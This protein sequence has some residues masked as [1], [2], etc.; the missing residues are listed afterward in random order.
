MSILERMPMVTICLWI[1]SPLRQENIAN[2]T[3]QSISVITIIFSILNA[4]NLTRFI[5]HIRLSPS[6]TG[7]HFALRCSVGSHPRQIESIVINVET[8]G[9][10][11]HLTIF[12]ANLT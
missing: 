9:S 12:N 2:V 5:S 7:W 10:Y 11:N 8:L 1:R 4:Y 3:Y 6:L